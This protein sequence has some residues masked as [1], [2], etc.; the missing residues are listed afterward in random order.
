MTVKKVCLKKA[1]C[2]LDLGDGS[3]RALYV[4]QDYNL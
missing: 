3:E 1:D 2:A 4:N